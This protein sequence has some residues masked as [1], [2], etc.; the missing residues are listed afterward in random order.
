VPVIDLQGW[1]K[2]GVTFVALSSSTYELLRISNGA[3][4][5]LVKVFAGGQMQLLDG[6]AAAPTILW[7]TNDGIFHASGEIGFAIGGAKVGSATATG[8]NS[9]IGG[10]T[11][12][13]SVVTLVG[14]GGFSAI[15]S[16]TLTDFY[17][18]PIVL[19]ANALNTD[20]DF[21]RITVYGQ[22]VIG[23]ANDTGTIQFVFGATVVSIQLTTVAAA[24]KIYP[25]VILITVARLTSSNQPIVMMLFEG[26]DVSTTAGTLRGT[27]SAAGENLAANVNINFRGKDTTIVGTPAVELLS[28]TVEL[29]RHTVT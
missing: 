5:P 17:S 27:A 10:S 21:L 28:A 8:L 11:T 15:T 24:N 29:I 2:S 1:Q 7:G 26:T 19:P 18:S 25:F 13:G 23:S 4:T 16:T 9:L 12:L 3:S 6:T 22:H 14:A 20:K